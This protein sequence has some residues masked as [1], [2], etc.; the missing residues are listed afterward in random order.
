MRK[1]EDERPMYEGLS[2]ERKTKNLKEEIE[3]K[4]EKIK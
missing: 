1:S 3:Y 4:E 2:L